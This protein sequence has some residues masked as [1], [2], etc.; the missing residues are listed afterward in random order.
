MSKSAKGNKHYSRVKPADPSSK[1]ITA[2][3][4]GI[5]S[6]LLCFIPIMLV[7]AV[8]G[9]MTERDSEILGYHRLQTPARILCIIGTVLCSVVIVAIII[10]VLALGVIS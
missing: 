8:L 6:I 9:I 2:F 1:T 4:F 5:A 3:V 10:V 7:V